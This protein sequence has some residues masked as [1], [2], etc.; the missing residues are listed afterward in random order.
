MSIKTL[1]Q[2]FWVFYNSSNF[3]KAIQQYAKLERFYEDCAIRDKNCGTPDE[4]KKVYLK[5]M[6]WAI[7]QIHKMKA[8]QLEKFY[9]VEK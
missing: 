1:T 8:E 6:S 5:S 7:I 3:D 2:N 9:E 4:Y